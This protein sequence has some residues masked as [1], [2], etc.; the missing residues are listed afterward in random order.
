VTGLQTSIS[1]RQA[2]YQVV[3]LA[4]HFPGEK[5]IEYTSPWYVSTTLAHAAK[6]RSEPTCSG[7]TLKGSNLRDR[8][9]AHWRSHAGKEDLEQQQWDTETYKHMLE[10]IKTEESEPGQGQLSG[11]AVRYSHLVLSMLRLVANL[12]RPIK[13][14]HSRYF[15]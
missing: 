7:H 13:L 14:C 10:V 3:L 2:G 4:K 1:L 12:G 6:F 11:L 9:G 5:S 8:A 15:R